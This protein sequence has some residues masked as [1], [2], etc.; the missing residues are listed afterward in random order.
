MSPKFNVLFSGL[1]VAGTYLKES[2]HH[3]KILLREKRFDFCCS[4]AIKSVTLVSMTELPNDVKDSCK[5]S[6]FW[7]PEAGMYLTS[8]K[9]VSHVLHL[10]QLGTEVEIQK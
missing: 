4:Q 7:K 1:R 8:K 6:S 10:S 3:K 2:L 9:M 5:S